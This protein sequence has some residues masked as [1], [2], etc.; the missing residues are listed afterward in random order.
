MLK[1]QIINLVFKLAEIVFFTYEIE[2]LILC[3][4]YPQKNM[5]IPNK[6]I[7]LILRAFKPNQCYQLIKQI[8][9]MFIIF[10]KEF[11]INFATD[12]Y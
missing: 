6:A 5:V 11:S 3:F 7:L 4:I 2:F 10:F 1:I 9:E 8:I 12:R